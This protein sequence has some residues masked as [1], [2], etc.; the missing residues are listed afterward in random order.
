MRPFHKRWSDKNWEFAL[1]FTD[2]KEFLSEIAVDLINVLLAHARMDD[3]DVR[4]N[5]F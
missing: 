1:R 2:E 5:C 4:E 3:N